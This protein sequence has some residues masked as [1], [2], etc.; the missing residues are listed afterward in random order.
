MLEGSFDRPSLQ[1]VANT[2]QLHPGLEYEKTQQLAERMCDASL[3]A[4]RLQRSKNA[5]VFDPL[6]GYRD[7]K[8]H[9]IGD[10]RP[11]A[12]LNLHYPP[13]VERMTRRGRRVYGVECAVKVDPGSM[14]AIIMRKNDV[15][16]SSDPTDWFIATHNLVTGEFH[17]REV[18]MLDIR[19]HRHNDT[20]K[21]LQSAD[22]GD[23]VTLQVAPISDWRNA[24]RGYTMIRCHVSQRYHAIDDVTA[25]R[26]DYHGRGASATPHEI[27][28]GTYTTDIYDLHRALAEVLERRG[29]S[30]DLLD[31][32]LDPRIAMADLALLS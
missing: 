23:D 9:L 3:L 5:Q 20:A 18:I 24:N 4:M 30:V 15:V 32:A 1:E 28:E 21:S 7:L 27:S 25:S 2:E 14:D 12:R 11:I 22:E 6:Q 31:H 26:F 13:G 19:N 16:T 10:V 17:E 29:L 8:Y